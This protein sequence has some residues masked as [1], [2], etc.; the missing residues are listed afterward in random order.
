M[1]QKLKTIYDTPVCNNVKC[2]EEDFMV[3]THNLYQIF[4]DESGDWFNVF[5]EDVEAVESFF[6]KFPAKKCLEDDRVWCKFIS[7]IQYYD[8]LR[9]FNQFKP[10][11]LS[12]RNEVMSDGTNRIYYVSGFLPDRMDL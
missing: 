1:R 2:P 4:C 7:V 5:F 3:P 11:E 9:R 6:V 12:V 8:S 10:L